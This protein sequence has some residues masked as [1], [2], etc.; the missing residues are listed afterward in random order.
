LADVTA[1]IDAEL[2]KNNSPYEVAFYR[3]SGNLTVVGGVTFDIHFTKS[4][5]A[6]EEAEFLVLINPRTQKQLRI[7][8]KA[9]IG[10]E[11]A[12][13]RDP[14]TQEVLRVDVKNGIITL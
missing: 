6:K 2:K 4:S 11:Y 8:R 14:D 1:D 7:P 12:Q 9:L 5:V 3:V 10:R 13:V